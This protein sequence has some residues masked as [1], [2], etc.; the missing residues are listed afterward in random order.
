MKQLKNESE[1]W[2]RQVT[3]PLDSRHP[4]MDLIESSCMGEIGVTVSPVAG[5]AI[6]FDHLID[7]QSDQ[8]NVNMW[9]AGCN[10]IGE[11]EE[12]ILLQKFKEKKIHNRENQQV[13]LHS[14]M[15][16]IFGYKSYTNQ[17]RPRRKT[18]RKKEKRKKEK[19]KKKSKEDAEL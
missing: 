9:H 6:M 14:Q 13:Q 7:G 8:P 4:Y 15:T 2:N 11:F 10:V 12:K 17:G 3:F 5:T 18:K 19:R 1:K 16:S